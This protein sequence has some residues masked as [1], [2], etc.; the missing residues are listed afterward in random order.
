MLIYNFVKLRV[1]PKSKYQFP[2]YK[3]VEINMVR[4]AISMYKLSFY[5]VTVS[6]FRFLKDVY[7]KI[8]Y[9]H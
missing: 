8:S 2:L 3:Y 9:H 5:T 1:L 4:G 6:A 7:V